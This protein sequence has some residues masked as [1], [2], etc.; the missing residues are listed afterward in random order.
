MINTSTKTVLLF[1]LAV[2]GINS[3]KA[4]SGKSF[5]KGSLY[6][7]GMELVRLT[8]DKAMSKN[9]MGY[10]TT[11]PAILNITE[12]FASGNYDVPVHVYQIEL[13]DNKII[14]YVSNHGLI[15]S[16]DSIPDKLKQEII[17]KFIQGIPSLIEGMTKVENLAASSFL[18]SQLV[19][20][21]K[22]L[23]QNTVLLYDFKDATPI[24][25]VFLKGKD[26]TFIAVSQPL[27][28]FDLKQLN[29]FM[30]NDLLPVSEDNDILN[31]HAP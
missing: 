19:S 24:A 20:V 12:T 28:G 3:C 26:N 4:Q 15:D 31:Q 23:A 7:T 29:G 10:L 8:V 18:I 2:F 25:V 6:E 11:H 1:L 21:N 13:S 22:E 16:F 5:D 9:Y 30:L 27:I 14:Q 17:N